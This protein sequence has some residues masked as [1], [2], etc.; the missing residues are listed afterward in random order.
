[1]FVMYG[2]PFKTDFYFSQAFN[3]IYKTV[4]LLC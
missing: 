3:L 4:D 1:M 2:G